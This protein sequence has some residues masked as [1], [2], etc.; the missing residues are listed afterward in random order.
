ML[1]YPKK[2]EPSYR[3]MRAMFLKPNRSTA[4]I[5]CGA[6]RMAIQ[7]VAIG[8]IVG[9]GTRVAWDLGIISYSSLVLKDAAVALWI[10]LCDLANT[11]S[12]I[13]QIVLPD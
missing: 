12:Q 2:S 4:A 8:L 7:G 3:E 1:P 13:F 6:N 10:M 5:D 9:I 11:C